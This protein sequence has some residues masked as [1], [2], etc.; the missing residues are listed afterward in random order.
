VK[1]WPAPV[2]IWLA[3]E[4]QAFSDRNL[5]PHIAMLCRN[6]V[7]GLKA[8][9]IM[10]ASLMGPMIYADTD[11]LWFRPPQQLLP[12]SSVGDRVWLRLQEDRQ[13]AYDSRLF[14]PWPFLEEEP[15]YC[16]G[17]MV[18]SGDLR[19]AFEQITSPDV[20]RIYETPGQFTEQTTFAALQRKIGS[21][22][23]EAD[24]AYISWEDRFTLR[25][26][27]FDKPWVL[28]HYVG[29]VRH[30]YWRDLLYLYWRRA[31]M[32]VSNTEIWPR[33]QIGSNDIALGKA[34]TANN[35]KRP[36][37]VLQDAIAGGGAGVRF[38]AIPGA[39]PIEGGLPIVAHGK[40]IGAIGVSGAA[41][42]E[43]AQCAVAG[44][45]AAVAK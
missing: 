42:N 43:D 11:V 5:P 16:A 38:L 31:L 44:A 34:T 19:P 26:R 37:K 3:D 13:M 2:E 28:R 12:D 14:G 21:P 24:K 1:W 7:Y 27:I 23:L 6:H 20:E 4:L 36:T 25:P 40:I 45:A 32:K 15:H 35:L 29:P 30:L 18:A 39:L 22:A 9:A 41:S 10:R 8:A 17:V 33:W